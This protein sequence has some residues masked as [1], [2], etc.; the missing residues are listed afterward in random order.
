VRAFLL[1]YRAGGLEATVMDRIARALTD[2]EI[3]AVARHYGE[4]AE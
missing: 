1:G 4:L 3:E 2:E